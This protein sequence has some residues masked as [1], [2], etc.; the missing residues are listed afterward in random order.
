MHHLIK[1]PN[2]FCGRSSVVEVQKHV[3]TL[4]EENK[5]EVGR[6]QNSTLVYVHKP[7]RN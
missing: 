5:V 6:N 3:Y 2:S 1:H 4:K 7:R